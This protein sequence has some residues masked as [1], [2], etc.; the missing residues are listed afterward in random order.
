MSSQNYDVIVIGARCAGAAT[1]M[2]MARKGLRVLLAERAAPGTDTL[3]SHNLTRGAVTQLARWGVVDRL[4]KM[5]TPRITQSVFHFGEDALALDLKPAMGAPGLLGTRRAILDATLVDAAREAGVD[6]R[7]HTSFKD[8][9]RNAE[10]RVTGAVLSSDEDELIVKAPL[11]VGADGMRSTVARRVGAAMQK[12]AKNALGHIYSYYRGLPLAE[13]HLFF[14]PGA[15]I[16]STPTD[17]GADIV[18]ATITPEKL[19]QMRLEVGDRGALERLAVLANPEFANLLGK[20]EM[21]EPVR[22][23]SG[24]KGFSRNCA[25]PG[26][27]LVGDA[28][29][30]RDPVTAHGITDA[31][32]DAELLANAAGKGDAALTD[33]QLKRDEITRDIWEITDQIAAF[34][35]RLEELQTAYHRLSRAMRAEQE[36]MASEFDPTALA[37]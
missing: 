20:A 35:M 19:R 11:V 36:W 2:L 34:D 17:H 27:A 37:A 33:Y 10:G 23:F 15:L 32:R 13:S 1:A 6:V 24:T 26:W 3:S 25:G 7:F 29:Y 12:E 16:A 8:V 30:F 9:I 21:I 14:G 22:A 18:I 31:F 5:G 4:I 28:G